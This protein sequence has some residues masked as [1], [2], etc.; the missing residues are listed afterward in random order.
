[1]VLVLKIIMAITETDSAY[2]GGRNNGTGGDDE[3]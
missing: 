3:W 1:M 2:D